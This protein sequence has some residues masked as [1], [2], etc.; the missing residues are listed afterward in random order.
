MQTSESPIPVDGPIDPEDVH[1]GKV[2][3]GMLSLFFCY[4]IVTSLYVLWWTWDSI[5]NS[6]FH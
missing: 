2:L 1:A 3:G 4:T 6:V 5:Q